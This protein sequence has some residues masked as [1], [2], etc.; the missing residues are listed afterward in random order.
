MNTHYHGEWWI[1]TSVFSSDCHFI[2]R[3][4][5][6]LK[7]SEI[8]RYYSPVFIVGT[9]R[10]SPPPLPFFTPAT[11]DTYMYAKTLEALKLINALSF[12]VYGVFL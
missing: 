4:L 1:W 8:Y 6:T 5:P 7:I 11:L 10:F 9:V 3:F 12:P 2:D